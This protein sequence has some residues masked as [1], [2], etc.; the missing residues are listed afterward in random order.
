MLQLVQ[1]AGRVRPGAS[2]VVE[3]HPIIALPLEVESQGEPLGQRTEVCR[4]REGEAPAVVEAAEVD[5]GE[6]LRVL[7]APREPEHSGRYL[8]A[9]R[10]PALQREPALRLGDVFAGVASQVEGGSR[11]A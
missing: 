9:V 7:E 10:Q 5:I 11:I 6:G 4:V 1:L 8:A 3:A 2:Q